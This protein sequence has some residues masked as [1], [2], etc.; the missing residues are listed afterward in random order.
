MNITYCIFT[1]KEDAPM[2][3][4]C[5]RGLKL[6]GSREQNI[7][8]FDDGRNPT[9]IPLRGC[10]YRR[11]YFNRNGN[12]NGQECTQ[13]E[14][15]CMGEAV[16]HT[17]ADLIIK[18]DSDIILNSLD[19]VQT[20][21]NPLV[22]HIGFHIGEE[23]HHIS[24]CCYSLPAH[25]IKDM[26]SKL[27]GLNYGEC[28]GE[29]IIISDLSLRIGLIPQAYECSSKNKNPWR[30]AS[31]YQT[32]LNGDE[33]L[34]EEYMELFMKKDV[35]LCDLMGVDKR[36]KKKNARIMKNF[37]DNREKRLKFV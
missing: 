35:V 27:E 11:T 34:K 21:Y 15:K 2:V 26:L 12:L 25:K 17:G 29:S 6:L 28:L 36:D 7:F 23:K 31:I 32:M 8:V 30:A 3:E 37:L 16:Y 13:G 19:W 5:I 10:Q 20:T 4:Q 1:Y 33:Q 14:L 9:Q 18:I 24:G 22:R